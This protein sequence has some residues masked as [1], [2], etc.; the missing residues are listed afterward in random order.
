MATV[1]TQRDLYY[2]LLDD[3]RPPFAP[4]HP[5]QVAQ[6]VATLTRVLALP[7]R[8]SLHI[9]CSSKGL[10]GGNLRLRSDRGGP[11]ISGVSPVEASHVAGGCPHPHPRRGGG[12]GGGGLSGGY[13][14]PGDLRHV[15]HLCVDI[16]P[17]TR[18]ILV[19]EK[20]A[21]FQTLLTCPVLRA[22]W[23]CVLVTARGMPDEVG[24]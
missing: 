7:H 23:P 17:S 4:T 13:P 16:F 10:V 1:S 5:R 21:V 9:T 24:R 3:L 2:T 14:I 12:G 6:T 18:G 15:S 11:W 20:D 22:T 8:V 19:V